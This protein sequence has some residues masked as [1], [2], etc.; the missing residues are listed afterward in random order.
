MAAHAA[1]RAIVT[2]GAQGIGFAVARRLVE[3]GCR[4]VT[5]VGR[6]AE[7]GGKA[8]AELEELGAGAIFVSADVQD[9]EACR[10]A[11][12]TAWVI[13]GSV[14]VSTPMSTRSPGLVAP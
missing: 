10:K 11:V 1:T 13:S 8:V 12:A 14:W 2:G 3:E 6:S 4:A 9:V 7:K 5:L